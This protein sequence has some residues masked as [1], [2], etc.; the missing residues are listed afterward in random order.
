MN[1]NDVLMTLAGLLKDNMQGIINANRE[2]VATCDD[3]DASMMDRLKLNED[4]VM[5][6]ISSIEKII[7][8]EDPEN[9][10]LYTFHHDNGM[11]IENRTVPI[12]KILIIYESR[13]DV[14]IEASILAFKAGNKVLLKG[15]KESRATNTLLV[16]L[17]K[18]A[19]MANQ[20]DVDYI[21][22]LDVN[23]E[24]IQR[25]IKENTFK[26]D[27]IIPRGGDGLINF[28]NQ[29]TDVPI[30]V[31]GRGNNFLFVDRESDFDMAINVIL[32]G[33]TRV[34]VCN[35]LDKVLLHR[36]IPELEEKLL[37]LVNALCTKGITIYGDET[38]KSI[39]NQ[40]TYVEDESIWS[41]EF[42]DYKIF[43][44]LVSDAEHAITLINQ[45][46]GGHSSTIISNNI[47]VA[48]KFLNRVDSAAVYHNASTRF[49]DGGQFGLGAEIAISTQ[50]L[51]FRGPLGLD[52]LV[53]NKWY[54]YGNGQVRL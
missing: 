3:T 47:E 24:Q 14:T 13:P 45:H 35:A 38:I 5:G 33:K 46:S 1:K 36:D 49:T 21:T 39:E 31:S 50:K 44:S 34:S 7:K 19:L 27:L 11:R 16:R 22:Y 32:N 28:V 23:K 20:V 41:E 29:N 15:G 6:M 12:G 48:Q 43:L 8:S 52:Q 42:L 37:R 4:K 25:I 10:L 30:I 17:W 18:E 26:V 2:D 40:V 51:H 54:V 53:S 9:K